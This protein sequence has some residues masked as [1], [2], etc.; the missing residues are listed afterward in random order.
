MFGMPSRRHRLARRNC[1]G[2]CGEQRKDKQDARTLL[3]QPYLVS[4]SRPRRRRL[5]VLGPI[6]DAATILSWPFH[7]SERA[8]D[9]PTVRRLGAHPRAVRKSRARDARCSHPRRA[10]CCW[11]RPPERSCV[12]GVVC[13]APILEGARPGSHMSRGPQSLGSVRL[14]FRRLIAVH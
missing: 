13:S 7:G 10:I 6:V 1:G 9:S 14:P 3:E 5:C 8:A 2:I 12:V 11:P 4:R